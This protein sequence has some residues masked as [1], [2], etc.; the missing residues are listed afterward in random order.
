M[1]LSLIIRSVFIVLLIFAVT[2]A[3][4]TDK[5]IGKT[6]TLKILE[7]VVA[8]DTH[9]KAGEYR[10]THVV[11]GEQHFMVLTGTSSTNKGEYRVKCQMKT[12]PSK[13]SY[14]EQ[15]LAPGP[16]GEN[17]LMSVT[18]QGDT[19]EHVFGA[20]DKSKN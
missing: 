7:P 15:H 2:C 18:F 10:V 8:G 9:L 19:V 5:T 4:A 6:R 11:E 3:V 13:A 12:L 20:S 16:S 1:R 14:D 17:I